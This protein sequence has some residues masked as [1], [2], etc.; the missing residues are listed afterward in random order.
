[1]LLTTLNIALGAAAAISVIISL[2]IGA[3]AIALFF[4]R[5]PFVPTPRKRVA[6]ILDLLALK[7]NDVFYDLGCGEGRFLIAAAK[8]GAKATGFEITPWAYLRGKLN[9]WLTKSP[10]EILY[11]NFYQADLSKADSVYCFLIDSVMPKVEEKLKKE[12]KPG[13]KIVCYGFK[14]PTWPPIKIISTNPKN[15]KASKIYLYQ[16]EA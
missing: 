7:Q 4:C 5:V 1:M 12:L 6:E 15:K 8:R 3:S 16:K 10:A 2:T 14:L 11:Q 9:L 13:A